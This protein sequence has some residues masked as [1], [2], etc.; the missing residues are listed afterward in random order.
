MNWGEF[1]SAVNWSDVLSNITSSD[2]VNK[3]ATDVMGNVIDN[4]I[5]PD[6]DPHPEEYGQYALKC[7]F[8]DALGWFSLPR[9][10]ITYRANG[11]TGSMASQV[12]VALDGNTAYTNIRA[13][14]F[15]IPSTG[16]HFIGWKDENGNSYS[17]GQIV[18]LNGDLE[19]SAQW[20]NV[21]TLT[22]VC[23]AGE[24]TLT[25]SNSDT[26]VT[27]ARACYVGGVNVLSNKNFG[28]FKTN[29]DRIDAV[30]GTTFGALV[31]I[32][33][34]S[35]DVNPVID[36]DGATSD[37]FPLD[38]SVMKN[39]FGRYFAITAD[40]TVRFV[41]RDW[42]VTIAGITAGDAYWDCYVTNK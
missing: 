16:Y 19:L 15:G 13:N 33:F 3:L 36:G 42:R 6:M 23:E 21:Y 28:T 41:W 1:W 38:S 32:V 10:T 9:R 4:V 27:E 25:G 30:Y 5:I 14:G 37:K 11:G 26:G 40:T 22:L 12:V 35:Q 8:A 39:G 34:K 31:G 24:G 7:S 29:P 17:E 2:F 18:G 20:S